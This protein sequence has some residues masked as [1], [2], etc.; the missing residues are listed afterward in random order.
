[1]CSGYIRPRNPDFHLYNRQHRFQVACLVDF[2]FLV[3]LFPNRAIQECCL[4]ERLREVR[5]DTE[6]L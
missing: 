1:M 5:L 2:G 6:T 4:Q 3:C